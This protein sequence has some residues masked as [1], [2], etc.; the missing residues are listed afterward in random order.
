MKGNTITVASKPPY[1]GMPTLPEDVKGLTALVLGANGISGQAMLGVLAENPE[2]WSTVIAVSRKQSSRSFGPT[3]Q[4][5]SLDLLQ[6][7]KIIAKELE[8]FGKKMWVAS[9]V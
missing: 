6:E 8:A 5:L 4:H 9:H 2:R 7:P 3:V 1:Y